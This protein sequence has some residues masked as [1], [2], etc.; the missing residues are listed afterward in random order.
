MNI[1]FAFRELLSYR[2]AIGYLEKV[3]NEDDFAVIY[4]NKYL[5][6]T[7]T[8]SIL[9]KSSLIFVYNLTFLYY[10]IVLKDIYSYHFIENHIFIFRSV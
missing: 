4:K 7:K 5:S 2:R 9:Y 3:S 1:L 6:E 10:E 8:I